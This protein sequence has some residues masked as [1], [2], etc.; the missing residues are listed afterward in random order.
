[1]TWEWHA[2]LITIIGG[3]V[4][5]LAVTAF[6]HFSKP[7]AEQMAA[8]N[9]AKQM[10]FLQN[11][12]MVC[13]QAVA[14]A[15]NFGIVPNYAALAT[16]LPTA[17]QA[18]GRYACVSA[19]TAARYVILVDLMCRDFKNPRCIALYSVLQPDGTVLYRRQR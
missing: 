2:A 17:T 16:R 15:K 13:T 5:A 18:Q 4:L 14:S 11:V 9:R 1:L 8:A 19:T 7:S 12:E 3:A 10:A 6:V